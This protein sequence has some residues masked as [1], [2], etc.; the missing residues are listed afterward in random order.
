MPFLQKIE[1]TE[2]LEDTTS[3]ICWTD[4]ESNLVPFYY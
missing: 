1:E 2:V 3:I 4:H